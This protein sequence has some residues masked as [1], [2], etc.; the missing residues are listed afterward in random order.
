MLQTSDRVDL[1]TQQY[2]KTVAQVFRLTKQISDTQADP[3]LLLGSLFGH[4]LYVTGGSLAVD[5]SAY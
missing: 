4:P 5:R 1:G 2:F 3:D